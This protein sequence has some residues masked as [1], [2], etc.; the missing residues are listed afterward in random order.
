MSQNRLH[1]SVCMLSEAPL[2]RSCDATIGKSP[3]TATITPGGID[4]HS[5]P[6][7]S[8]GAPRSSQHLSTRRLLIPCPRP[9]GSLPLGWTFESPAAHLEGTLKTRIP[10]GF[11]V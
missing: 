10:A 4:R 1:L 2:L 5:D 11:L 9:T 6:L 8:L 3:S 7:R